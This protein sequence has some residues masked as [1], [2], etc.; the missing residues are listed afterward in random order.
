MLILGTFPS[1]TQMLT[2]D[3]VALAES[4]WDINR[5]LWMG[6]HWLRLSPDET[7]NIRLWGVKV[8]NALPSHQSDAAGPVHETLCQ[9]R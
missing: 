9:V 5:L 4:P 1:R 2:Y 3:E 7:P 8:A 6:T